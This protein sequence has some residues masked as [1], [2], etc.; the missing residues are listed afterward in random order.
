MND[1]NLT[2]D[3]QVID[4]QIFE[5]KYL[6]F[7]LTQPLV[8]FEDDFPQIVGGSESDTEIESLNSFADLKDDMEGLENGDLGFDFEL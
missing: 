5:R 4:P 7:L 1:E 3:F 6:N 2:Y 8:Y